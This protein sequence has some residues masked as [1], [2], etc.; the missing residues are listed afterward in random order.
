MLPANNAQMSVCRTLTAASRADAAVRLAL[1][2]AP[3]GG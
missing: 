2:A 3:A 1:T